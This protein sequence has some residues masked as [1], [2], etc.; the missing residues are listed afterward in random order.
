[1]AAKLSF[2]SVV[3]CAVGATIR[4][5]ALAANGTEGRVFA[6]FIVSDLEESISCKELR[7]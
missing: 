5:G 6:E 1:M 3:V 2:M 7:T 4:V